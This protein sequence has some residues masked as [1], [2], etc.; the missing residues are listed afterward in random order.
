LGQF[1]LRLDGA[2]ILLASR[3]AQSLLAYLALSSG[4]AHRRE[5]LAGLLWPD[6]DDDNARNSLRHALWRTRKVLE[7]HQPALPFLVSDDLAIS[8]N[9][10]A[11]YWLD[12]AVLVRE[13]DTLQ[14]QIESVAAYRGELLP[15]FYDDW[16]SLE[17]ERLEAV[18]QHKMQRLLARLVEERRWSDVLEWGERWVA[19]GH[20]PE[21]G[22][23]ALMQ[24]HAEL[25]DRPRV[26]QA[27]QRCREALFNELG[28]EPSVAT[29]RLYARLCRDEEPTTITSHASARDEESAPGEPPY[30]GLHYF[31]EADSERFF[32]RERLTQ[33]LVDRMET[34]SFLAVIG[35]SGSGKSSIIRAGLVPLVK[36][37]GAGAVYVFTPT[38]N[39]LAELTSRLLP[40][41]S[42]GR[43][44]AAIIEEVSR[45]PRGLARVLARLPDRRRILVVDQFEELFTLCRDGFEREAFVENLLTAAERGNLVKLVIA[46]RAD[47]YA[48]CAENG[49]LREV[50]GEHQEYVGLM[51][52]P[53][54]RRAIEGPAER[55][56]WELEP[57]LVDV[58]LRDIG[59]E[60]GALPLLS[61]A[62]LETWKRRKGRQLTLSGY[63]AADPYG[64]PE[65]FRRRL[66]CVYR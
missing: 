40:D 8:F 24:A 47:F 59:E 5:K 15:G 9:A 66:G 42:N 23:R 16:V 48:F 32:G 31:D 53:E 30:Q 36:Q 11:D 1:E 51:S 33:R 29:R 3:P 21:P 49:R 65:R 43:N 10:G 25:G 45:D 54:L 62:L 14:Q 18:F 37:A 63:A 55:S 26:A 61:H 52:L 60:P 56:G 17:R 44:R 57:G 6:A 28:V 46:L 22:Y 27:Y 7:P 50:V 35:A 58:L 41:L 39:P 64:R 20:A 4:T 34:E 12:A 38:A 13:P 2:A 19:L